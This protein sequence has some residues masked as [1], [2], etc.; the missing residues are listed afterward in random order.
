VTVLYMLMYISFMILQLNTRDAA[1]ARAK[2]A[3]K[4]LPEGKPFASYVADDEGA[5]MGERV[6][7][8]TLE[9]MGPFLI[10]LWMCA[11]FVSCE[12]ATVLGSVAIV[13]RCLMPL[14]WSMGP[15]G[16]WNIKVELSTQP[17]YICVT[18]M[19][20]ATFFW[21]CTGINVVDAL[22]L[23]LLVGFVPLAWLVFML[24]AV[25]VSQFFNR[26]TKGAYEQTSKQS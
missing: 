10:S 20:G 21:S 3:G 4:T 9:Q 15:G 14:L 6:F 13:A 2:V 23:P 25:F 5:R 11:A 7:L 24:G 18:A 1:V 17:Y 8:N 16:A 19:L 26:L 22:S 12:L